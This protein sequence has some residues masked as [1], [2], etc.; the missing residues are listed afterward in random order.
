[1]GASTS[2][3]STAVLFDLL[4]GRPD[5]LAWLPATKLKLAFYDGYK[6]T[7]SDLDSMGD[8]STEG[9]GLLRRGS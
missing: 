3:G 1:M 2:P 6:L 7:D 4:L 9:Q 5:V 8:D